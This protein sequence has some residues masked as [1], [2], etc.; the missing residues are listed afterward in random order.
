MLSHDKRI[1][2][3]AWIGA[4]ALVGALATC[5]VA[6]QGQVYGYGATSCGKFASYNKEA[7]EE[8]MVWVSGYASN[9]SIQTGVKYFDGTDAEG[10]LLWILNYCRAHP[11]EKFFVAT[12]TLLLELD[13]KQSRP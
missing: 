6:A 11:L 2:M 3:K 10:R 7:Q 5:G 1:M 4:V 9:M 13:V 8:Y 12:E